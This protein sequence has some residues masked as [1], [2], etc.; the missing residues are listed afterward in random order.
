MLTEMLQLAKKREFFD[1][2]EA[3]TKPARVKIVKLRT[4]PPFDVR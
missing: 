3:E 4:Y 2:K 1:K